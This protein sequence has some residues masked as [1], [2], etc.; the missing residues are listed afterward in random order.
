MESSTKK[1]VEVDPAFLGI[2]CRSVR[3]VETIF[4]MFT[5]CYWNDRS[6]Y[7][8]S[9][10]NE[11]ILSSRLDRLPK[12]DRPSPKKSGKSFGFGFPPIRKKGKWKIL[13]KFTFWIGIA[14]IHS[15]VFSVGQ[16][17]KGYK[18]NETRRALGVSWRVC[19]RSVKVD[20]TL[21]V[22]LDC[23]QHWPFWEWEGRHLTM[24]KENLHLPSACF[25]R[26]S[27]PGPFLP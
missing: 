26:C 18:W 25:K 21:L 24:Q 1:E 6:W 2:Y 27:P 20:I 16:K 9:E 13:E 22:S 12:W 8:Y 17:N 15:W 3:A 10:T 23:P 7:A 14:W 4:K 11:Y 5:G 19:L